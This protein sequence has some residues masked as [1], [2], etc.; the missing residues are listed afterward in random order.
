MP[1]GD[2][3]FSAKYIYI[4]TTSHA[5]GSVH[6]IQ[7]FILLFLNKSEGKYKMVLER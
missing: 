6:E 7:H 1:G 5:C 2:A 4:D 3:S